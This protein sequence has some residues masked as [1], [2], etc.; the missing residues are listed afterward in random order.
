[1][2]R[3]VGKFEAKVQTKYLTLA[4]RDGLGSRQVREQMVADGVLE[5]RPKK[6]AVERFQAIWHTAPQKA[7]EAIAELIDE[8]RADAGAGVDEEPERATSGPRDGDANEGEDRGDG[9]GAGAGRAGA[10]GGGRE[11]RGIA[12][13][14]EELP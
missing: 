10:H 7:R 5:D 13:A 6:T 3:L 4:R 1:M 8:W 2:H 14:S 11:A 12:A 9:A